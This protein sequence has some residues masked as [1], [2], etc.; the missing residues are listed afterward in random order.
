M[1][2]CAIRGAQLKRLPSLGVAASDVVHFRHGQDDEN[3]S[4]KWC[5]I[6]SHAL[7]DLR[8]SKEK[9]HFDISSLFCSGRCN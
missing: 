7:P 5:S 8:S 9:I 2:N 4:R 1:R 6:F 3:I